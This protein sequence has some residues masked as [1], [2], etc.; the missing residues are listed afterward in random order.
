MEGRIRPPRV[1]WA[2]YK[3]NSMGGG[4]VGFSAQYA[5]CGKAPMMLAKESILNIKYVK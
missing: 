1:D 2:Y 4:E 3:N 5:L